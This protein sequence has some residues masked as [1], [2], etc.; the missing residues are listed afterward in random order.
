MFYCK[1]VVI[2]RVVSPF[3]LEFLQQKLSNFYDRLLDISEASP[4]SEQVS[5]ICRIPNVGAQ[6]QNINVLHLVPDGPQEG[7]GVIRSL[8]MKKSLR[9]FQAEYIMYHRG[10]E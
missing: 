10:F 5:K 7:E 1:W 4:V 3:Y 9:C 6:F 8:V 2:V